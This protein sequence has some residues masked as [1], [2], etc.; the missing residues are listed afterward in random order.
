MS[1][2]VEAITGVG[3]DVTVITTTYTSP[4]DPTIRDVL[5]IS[6]EMGVPLFR[7]G[8]WPYVPGIGVET[9]LAQVQREIAG[10]EA[11]ARAVNV[12]LALPNGA[13]ETVGQAIWDLHWLI[14]AMDPRTV[15]YDFDAGHAVAEGGAGGWY[16]ALQ[17][18]LPRV[19]MVT[20]RDFFWKN[21]GG[22]W[23]P[24]ACPLGEGMVDWTKLFTALA[25]S[26]FRGPVSVA[27][28]YNP[29]DL[30]GAIR[31]D[32]GFIRRQIRAAY[33]DA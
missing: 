15:G 25:Q 8:Y 10:L 12:S 33:G 29:K 31:R 13:G 2:A 1:R 14:R 21:E 22:T 26:G 3:L 19:K 16:V 18:A 11:L 32:V 6:G 30:L 7:A 17:L 24:A 28:D 9:R 5:S 23:K 20:A 27:V 4:A